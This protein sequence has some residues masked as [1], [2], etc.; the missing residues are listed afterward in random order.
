MGK[1][2]CPHQPLSPSESLLGIAF[3]LLPPIVLL[4]AIAKGLTDSTIG[5]QRC[6]K[7]MEF[8]SSVI[9]LLG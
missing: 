9:R 1:E 8:G 6:F 5:R 2:E 4:G 7:E 3:N